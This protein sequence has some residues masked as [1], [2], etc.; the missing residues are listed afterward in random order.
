MT[1]TANQSELK[2]FRY[3]RPAVLTEPKT[4]LF[5][6]RTR[7]LGFNVQV[8]RDGG[9]TNLHAHPGQDAVWYVLGGRAKFYDTQEHVFCDIG[10]NEAVAIPHAAPYWFE[11]SSDEPL[12]IIRAS[13][14]DPTAND[15]R[16]NFSA[17]ATR[18][19]GMQKESELLDLSAHEADPMQVLR[20]DSPEFDE[21]PK[22]V[23]N[24]WS[25]PLLKFHFQKIRDG[26]ETNLHAH[27]NID[28]AWFVVSGRARFYD[29]GENVF[30]LGKH[31]GVSIPKAVPYWFESASDEP[32]DIMHVTAGD[33]RIKAERVNHDNLKTWQE[34][35]SLG[36]RDAT[37]AER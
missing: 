14:K 30:E 18:Q 24:V 26:G 34:D 22:K 5:L 15:E 9:E 36:G 33:P 23:T 20:Y 2:S 17:Y 12:E 28:S 37:A 29:K 21:G 16:M 32:L 6:V 7:L 13:A 3:E 19:V 27:T 4:H 8:I 35:I 31:E 11:S 25:S 1:Q 10:V